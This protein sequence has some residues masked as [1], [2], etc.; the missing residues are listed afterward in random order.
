MD[1]ALADFLRR[2]AGDPALASA[3]RR[4]PAQALERVRGLRAQ[5]RA[6]VIDAARNGSSYALSRRGRDPQEGR[7]VAMAIHRVVADFLRR[8]QN[9]PLL[10]R[11]LCLPHDERRAFWCTAGIQLRKVRVRAAER[12]NE[13]LRSAVRDPVRGDRGLHHAFAPAPD[14]L[15]LCVHSIGSNTGSQTWEVGRVTGLVDFDTPGDKPRATGSTEVTEY[16][17]TNVFD[18]GTYTV[19]GGPLP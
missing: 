6:M 1:R 17:K 4:A 8:V 16:M 3:L 18:V 2:L 10:V 14:A 9:D 12:R 5:D 13:P 7:A 11:S 15:Q 19:P